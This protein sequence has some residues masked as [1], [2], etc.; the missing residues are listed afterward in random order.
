MATI[1][2]RLLSKEFQEIFNK[3]N[4][5]CNGRH[6]QS[7]KADATMIYRLR[8]LVSYE[9]FQFE[10]T[11]IAKVAMK[12][13]KAYLDTF[14]IVNGIHVGGWFHHIGMTN[15]D[16]VLRMLGGYWYWRDGD[17]AYK[18]SHLNQIC[19]AGKKSSKHHI[20]LEKQSI[21]NA[22]RREVVSCECCGK[23]L[24]HGSLTRHTKK[25]SVV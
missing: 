3:N 13:Y 22:K 6:I 17:D 7:D 1:G 25:C 18:S 24:T 5:A 11:A 19:D 2:K 23:M 16:E 8:M 15:W 14:G 21:R 4:R 12:N 9:Q 10:R 20:K